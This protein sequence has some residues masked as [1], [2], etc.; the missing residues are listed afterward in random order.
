MRNLPSTFT[1]SLMLF[2][3]AVSTL[4]LTSFK[5]AE[6]TSATDVQFP[7][8]S[9]A[10]GIVVV[11]VS[12]NSK[13]EVSGTKVQRDIASLTAVATSS[14]QFWK[15]RPASVDGDLQNSVLRAAFAFRPNAIF[16]A[17]PMF[18]PLQ[19]SQDARADAKSGYIPPDILAVAY[20]AYPIDAA[21]VGAVV[22]QVNVDAEGKITGVKAIRSYNPFNRF[23]LEAARKWKFGPASFDGQPVAS[24]I[25]IAFV[26]SQPNVA[27]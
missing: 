17:S 22:V 26:Y 3:C 25:V 24:S 5:A 23:S 15:Y 14:I 6:L 20:P 4:A 18:E 13:G 1:L 8:G 16:A 19:R 7:A 12:L 27:N 2:C 21:T 10:S 11:D 9:I